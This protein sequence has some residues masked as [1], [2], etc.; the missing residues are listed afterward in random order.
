MSR[1]RK[2]KAMGRLPLLLL[3]AL[4]LLAGCGG[5]SDAK[6]PAAQ[7]P[8]EGGVRAKV[9]AAQSVTAADFPATSGRTLQQVAD[10]AGA[11]R[12][13]RARRAV[14]SVPDAGVAVPLALAREHA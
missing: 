2:L 1:F 5:G 12:A 13:D 9:R 11:C 4:A 6:D 8:A 14:A 7:V 3:V 10:A